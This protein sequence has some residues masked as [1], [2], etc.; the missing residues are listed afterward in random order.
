[1]QAIKHFAHIEEHIGELASQ[2][3]F[4]SPS[5]IIYEFPSAEAADEARE[6]VTDYE[7]TFFARN[8][9]YFLSLA[10]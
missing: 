5:K 8:N 6:L 2:M 10:L 3:V 4:A 1:M 7:P 9:R